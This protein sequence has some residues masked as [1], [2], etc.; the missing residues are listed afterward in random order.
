MVLSYNSLPYTTINFK[1]IQNSYVFSAVMI[2]F[3]W[4]K[5]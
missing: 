4:L 1:K 3:D 5:W 2:F